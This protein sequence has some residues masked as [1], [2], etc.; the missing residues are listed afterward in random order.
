MSFVSEIS[1]PPDMLTLPPI[2]IAIMA[3]IILIAS[4]VIMTAII[5]ACRSHNVVRH[6][7]V[8]DLNNFRIAYSDDEDKRVSN[9]E[10]EF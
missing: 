7:N 2:Y 9:Y 8:N 4:L 1:A 6:D 10:S 3:L 5:L